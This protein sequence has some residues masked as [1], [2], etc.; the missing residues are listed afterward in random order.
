M[1]LNLKDCTLLIQ[2]TFCAGKENRT[3]TSSLAKTC[4]TIKQYPHFEILYIKINFLPNK[5][6]L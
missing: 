1:T 5:K 2:S 4:P 3:P 6:N